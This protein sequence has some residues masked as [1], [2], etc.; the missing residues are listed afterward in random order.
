MKIIIEIIEANDDNDDN[1]ENMWWPIND[2]LLM[3]MK[4]QCII[5]IM[6]MKKWW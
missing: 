3:I 4:W 1:N 2:V 6:T 5:L